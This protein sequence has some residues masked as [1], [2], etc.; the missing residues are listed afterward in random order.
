M[1]FKTYNGTQGYL[2]VSPVNNSTYMT[3]YS[4]TADGEGTI[5]CTGTNKNGV[6]LS[7]QLNFTASYYARG[8]SGSLVA[9][10]ASV[11]IPKDAMSTNGTVV[12]ASNDSLTSYDGLIRMS[13]NVDLAI[14]VDQADKSLGITI[15]VN[16]SVKVDN[17]KVGLYRATTSGHKWVGPVT[18]SKGKAKGKIDVSASLFVAADETAPVISNDIEAIANGKYAVKVTDSG[19]GICSSTVEVTCD[20]NKVNSSYSDGVLVFDTSAMKSGS[21]KV[22]DVQASDNAGNT[23]R[24]SLRA[25]AGVADLSQIVAYPNPAKNH[26]VIRATVTGTN[27]NGGKGSVKIYDMSGHKVM[28]SALTDNN[29]G[30]YEF[31]WDLTNKKNKT[32]A[33]GTYLAEVKLNVGGSSYKKRIKIAVL[34]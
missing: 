2:T 7:N 12:L 30:T 34:H 33:N 22:F 14:P 28:E 23:S 6:I 4:V 21:I 20:G 31:D 25:V 27:P 5:V 10:Y 19:S 8:S 15:P 17:S 11:D 26:S 32:V 9:N 3:N 13:K 18:M 16:S 1:L 29:N 24:A